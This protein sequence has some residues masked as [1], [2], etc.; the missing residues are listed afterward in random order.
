MPRCQFLDRD[1]GPNAARSASAYPQTVDRVISR[2]WARAAPEDVPQTPVLSVPMHQ[3]A[4]ASMAAARTARL[5]RAA[6]LLALA[7][8]RRIEV[9]AGQHI[10][11]RAQNSNQHHR[12]ECLKRYPFHR[13]LPFAVSDFHFRGGRIIGIVRRLRQSRRCPHKLRSGG[14]K[15]GGCA[16]LNRRTNELRA[17]S[18]SIER[19]V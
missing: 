14:A 3:R 11:A 13:P 19:F 6:R 15:G 9:A 18:I 1:P 2:L 4:L 17:N 16:N 12:G 8:G 7:A 5:R 10:A